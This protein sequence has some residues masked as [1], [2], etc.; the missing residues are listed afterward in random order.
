[1]SG[2]RE[3]PGLADIIATAISPAL[4]MVMVGSLIFFLIEVLYGG[5]HSSQLRWTFSFF[6]F[7]AVLIARIA[8]E[9]G[10]TKASIYAALLGGAAFIA[11]VRFVEFDADS[12]VGQ[13]GWLVNIA[14]LVLVWWSARKLTWDCTHIDEEKDGSDRS[15]LE[16]AG[17]EDLERPPEWRE[18]PAPVAKAD[19]PVNA[20]GVA[21]WLE[22]Y[23]RFRKARG[24]K[25]HTPGTWVVYFSL[26]ALPVFG[27]GQALIPAEDQNSR[28]FTFWLMA[29][30]VGA[31][32]GLLM[33]TSFLGLRRY[34]KQ[35]KL[36]IPAK[37]AGMWL[38]VGS[39]LILLF[40]AIAAI[41]PR[42]N[43]ETPLVDISAVGSK[44]RDASDFA[45]NGDGK[46]KGDGQAGNQSDEKSQSNSSTEGKSKEAGKGKGQDDSN[47]GNGGNK[48]NNGNSGDNKQQGKDSGGKGDKSDKGDKNKSNDD[49]SPSGGKKEG[50]SKGSQASSKQTKGGGPRQARQSS[51]S[52]G[53]RSPSSFT[54][55][56]KVATALKWIV[57]AIMAL[58]VLYFVFRHGLKFLANF[59]PWAKQLLEFFRNFWANLFGSGQRDHKSDDP[60]PESEA[61]PRGRPFADFANPFESGT[62]RRQTPAELVTYSFAALEAFSREHGWERDPQETPLEFADR[63][64]RTSAELATDAPRL[65][66]LY[67]RLAY[68]RGSL[69]EASREQVKEF[70]RQLE[71]AHEEAITGERAAESIA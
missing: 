19:R 11:M 48:G 20:E 25:P 39:G 29:A 9:M 66:A 14:L 24:A 27:L 7:G 57:F 23:R 37:M 10:D 6:V 34:L 45:P 41:L 32:L 30:Y 55:L 63:L 4:I 52:G 68:A 65:A 13:F 71:L 36:K 53:S 70:W 5:E 16:V 1:M 47:K 62:A 15:L 17:I 51:R 38:G 3:M 31:G 18:P 8:I 56:G 50:Q 21:G 28:E 26:A 43:S 46:G 35:R 2:K 22:R 60:E 61:A 42:P 40:L 54:G 44:E 67:A 69:P 49:K 59:M 12:A 64:A 58:A 33:T